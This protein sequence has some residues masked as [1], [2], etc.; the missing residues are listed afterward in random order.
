LVLVATV[1]VIVDVPAPGAAIEVGLKL[2]VTPAG[3]PVAE[4]ATAESK[5]PEMV[6]VTTTGP[7]WPLAK[8]PEVGETEMLKVGL[9]AVVTVSDTVAVCVIPPPMPVTVI[10]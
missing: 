7:L 10:V 8:D 4:R 5:P 2:M 3:W 1:S 6:V 9:T